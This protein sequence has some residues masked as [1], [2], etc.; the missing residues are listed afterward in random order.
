MTIIERVPFQ[1]CVPYISYPKDNLELK[2]KK[3]KKRRKKKEE[4]LHFML[5]I[6]AFIL[7]IQRRLDEPCTGQARSLAR[8]VT[9]KNRDKKGFL[10]PNSLQRCDNRVDAL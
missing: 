6:T 9:H 2:K 10:S 5:F 7:F 8:S 4:E 1:L 3:K